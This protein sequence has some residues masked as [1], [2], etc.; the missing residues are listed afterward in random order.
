MN[1]FRREIDFILIALSV[2]FVILDMQF[3]FLM[4]LTCLNEVS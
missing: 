2:G 1:K 4:A 3:D